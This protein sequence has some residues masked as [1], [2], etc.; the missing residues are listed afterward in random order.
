MERLQETKKLSMENGLDESKVVSLKVFV[1]RLS[2]F[3]CHFVKYEVVKLLVNF[4]F[5]LS[6][7]MSQ[8]KMMSTG[9]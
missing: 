2:F 4:R 9:L 6:L 3:Y 1:T 5:I 7:E 8:T